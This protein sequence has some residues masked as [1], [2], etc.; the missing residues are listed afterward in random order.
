MKYYP[1]FPS[2]T[3]GSNPGTSVTEIH[4]AKQ[5]FSSKFIVSIYKKINGMSSMTHEQYETVPEVSTYPSFD[6]HRKPIRHINSLISFLDSFII[7]H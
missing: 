6:V 1:P 7:I 2:T 5:S 4:A 3:L